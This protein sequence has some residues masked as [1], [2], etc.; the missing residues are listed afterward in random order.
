MISEKYEVR[1]NPRTQPEMLEKADET[2]NVR[3]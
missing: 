1:M 3:N 2:L